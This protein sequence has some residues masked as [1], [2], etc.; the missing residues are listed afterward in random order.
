MPKN[1]RSFLVSFSLSPTRSGGSYGNFSDMTTNAFRGPFDTTATT[2]MDEPAVNS[3]GSF[4]ISVGKYRDPTAVFTID[5]QVLNN[6]SGDENWTRKTK[7]V[8]TIGTRE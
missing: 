1:S 3:V 7:I 2:D 8:A 4:N 5:S 6:L